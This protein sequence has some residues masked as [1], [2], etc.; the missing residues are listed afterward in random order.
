MTTTQRKPKAKPGPAKGEGGRPRKEV[1]WEKIDG[2]C[3]LYA[4]ANEIADYLHHFDIDVSYDTLDRRAQEDHGK[5]FAAYVQQKQSA[6]AKPKLRQL[7]WRAAEAGN[8]S[9]LIWLG[10][11]ILGQTDKQEISDTTDYAELLRRASS[12]ME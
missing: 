2:L 11:Q 4:P 7:Q 12:D 3:A 5:T 6:L 8:V 10:K 1:D 9:M